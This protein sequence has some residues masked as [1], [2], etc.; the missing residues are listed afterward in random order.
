ME[1]PPCIHCGRDRDTLEDLRVQMTEAYKL[2]E[3]GELAQA[4]FL[5]R[6]AGAELFASVNMEKFYR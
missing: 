2:L 4:K 6:Q 3:A 5:L 1:G